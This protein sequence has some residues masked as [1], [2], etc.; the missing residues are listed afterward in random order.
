MAID[1]NE[2]RA[3]LTTARLELEALA[4]TADE[5]AKPVELDQTRV[6]RVSRMDAMQAQAMSIETKRRRD[7]QLKKIEAALRRLDNDDFGFC[8]SCGEEINIERLKIELTALLCIEC[9]EKGERA[10]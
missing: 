10:K 9:A 3:L 4:E 8:I 6:G 1:K 7:L 5:A 2:F